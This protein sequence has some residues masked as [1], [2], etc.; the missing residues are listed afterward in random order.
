MTRSM[1]VHRYAGERII[2]EF[3][4]GRCIHTGDCTRA[5]PQVFDTRR[6]GRWVTPDAA[7]AADVARV[8]A[9][10]PTGALR[11]IDRDSGE[12]MAA[13][14]A[15]NSVQLMRDGPLYLHGEMWLDGGRL[16]GYRA[17]L[18]RCGASR[19]MPFCDNSHREAGFRDAGEPV[20]P[21]QQ[22]GPHDVSGPL[23]ISCVSDGP[24][25]I[26]GPFTLLDA[27]GANIGSAGQGSLCR[28]GA[29]QQ[30]PWCDGSHIATGFRV[31]DTD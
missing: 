3:E 11:C 20:A 21:P 2:V 16:P 25:C 22:V 4:L 29:S 28:C 18:C 23:R 19:L 9:A 26:D 1:R 27:A 13:P 7:D 14:P 31:P 8:C 10:C 15:R 17:A 6:S 5:L 12:L 30:K 24:L